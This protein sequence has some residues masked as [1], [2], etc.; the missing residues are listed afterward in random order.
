[1]NLPP[2][3]LLGIETST[4]RGSVALVEADRV[5]C[6]AHHDEPNAHAERIL[7]L[8]DECLAKAAWDRR[9][10]ERIAVGVGPGSF[11]GLRVG[12]ALAHGLGLG[13]GVPVL[14]VG[15][16][17][18]LAAGVPE[19]VPGPRVALLDARRG[20]LFAAVYA[21]DGS[22]VLAPGTVPRDEAPSWV[23][24]FGPEAV[25]VG[26]VAR[27]LPLAAV[28]FGPLESDWPGA[29]RV[30]LLARGLDPALARPV[31]QYCR[32]PGA[33]LPALPP[34]PFGGSPGR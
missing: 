19:S 29:D 32:G 33:T 14:G 20:E 9:S 15:S 24:R 28:R 26:K 10:V 23:E 25:L 31:P 13:L 17:R 12:I 21:P 7:L 5:V 2:V 3:R 27:S 11:V 4:Q 1:M 8:A 30:A 6:L 16:L 18:A 22:E 34:S